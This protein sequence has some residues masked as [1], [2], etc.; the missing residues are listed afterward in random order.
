MIFIYDQL[1]QDYG[2]IN[3][4]AFINLLVRRADVSQ[5]PQAD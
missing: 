4:E 1:Q 2:A 3:F 5:F